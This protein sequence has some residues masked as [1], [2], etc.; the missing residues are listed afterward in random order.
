MAKPRVKVPETATAGEIITIKTLLSHKM[1]S[2][3]HIGQDGKLIPRKIINTFTCEFNGELVF[4][5]DLDT[6]I[7]ANPFFEFTA[8]VNKA[9]TFKFT[10][11]DDDG[12]VT[13]TERGILV[14]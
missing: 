1:D 5:C 8:K 12:T 9:G 10:W 7:S 11:I 14:V 6:A 13:Q 2:G 3:F 4:S